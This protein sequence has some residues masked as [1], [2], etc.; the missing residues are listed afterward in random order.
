MI[1][2]DIYEDYSNYSKIVDNTRGIRNYL[3]C[4]KFKK[5]YGKQ[6]TDEINTYLQIFS[7]ALRCDLHDDREIERYF[8]KKIVRILYI[9]KENKSLKIL[10]RKQMVTLFV[11]FIAPVAYEKT[12]INHD[13]FAYYWII[14]V[15]RRI[16]ID[17]SLP[18]KKFLYFICYKG[19]IYKEIV[20]NEE[21]KMN[22][23]LKKYPEIS[24]IL[25]I[26]LMPEE[27][28][29]R[30]LK[31]KHKIPNKLYAYCIKQAYL[32]NTFGIKI[33]TLHSIFNDL[34]KE[35]LMS[36]EELIKY[37]KLTSI[38]TIYRGTD[39][40]EMIPRISWTLDK[41]IAEKYC[42]GQ[43]FSATIPKKRILAYF[44]TFE[45]EVLVWLTLDEINV[46]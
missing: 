43:L 14:I 15:C 29:I 22:Y 26:G 35:E 44:D 23:E 38:I 28:M 8:S 40:H 21:E 19:E 3:L 5:K 10:T 16:W 30:L 12:G 9:I 24:P 33:Q 25:R 41:R 36:T 20:L 2:E 11:D 18:I 46:N 1:D 39:A 37:E 32:C 13:S 17:M 6:L 27:N 31:F 7:E 42:T 45:Q 34:S 4:L